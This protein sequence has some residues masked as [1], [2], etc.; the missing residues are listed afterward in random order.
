M[1]RFDGAPEPLPDGAPAPRDAQFS[2]DAP[3][4]GAVACG[5]VVAPYDG[6]GCA[7]E[8]L[9]CVGSCDPGDPDCM[10]AC[11]ALDAECDACATRTVISCANSL[12]CQATWD[13]F[14]CCAHGSAECAPL[15]GVDLVECAAPVCD[16]HLI[17]YEACIGTIDRA[18][19]AEK[20]ALTCGLST[21]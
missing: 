1:P 10:D 13:E 15:S 18:V 16:E 4:D 7:E 9:A 17:D 8:T 6:P 21:M 14:A 5:D 19:C 2:P 12:G 20:V 3:E 11:V